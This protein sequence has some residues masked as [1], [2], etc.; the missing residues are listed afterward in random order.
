MIGGQCNSHHLREAAS[1][2]LIHDAGPMYLDRPWRYTKLIGRQLVRPSGDELLQDIALPRRKQGD[3]FLSGLG[4]RKSAT[5]LVADDNARFTLSRITSS[6]NGFSTK[7][8]A[9]AFIARTA[10]G[11]SP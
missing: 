7:S 6:L 11:T 8:M 10:R 5:L 4:F 2:H 1:L 3:N 9:P